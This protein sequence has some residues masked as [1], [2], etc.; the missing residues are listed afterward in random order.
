[1]VSKLKLWQ[2]EITIFIYK[3]MYLISK[4]ISVSYVFCKFNRVASWKKMKS[5]IKVR[6]SYQIT[7][8]E[9]LNSFTRSTYV[10]V[11]MSFLI[12]ILKETLV[13]MCMASYFDIIESWKLSVG[14]RGTYYCEKKIRFI[15]MCGGWNSCRKVQ[16]AWSPHFPLSIT[17]NMQNGNG[18]FVFKYPVK[19][20]QKISNFTYFLL[21][22]L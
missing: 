16:Y 3:L 10:N 7:Q 11:N 19:C 17:T 6:S 9:I 14:H 15:H 8:L 18:F 5:V 2:L 20:K 4:W 13:F 21:K 12:V 22:L 1:V